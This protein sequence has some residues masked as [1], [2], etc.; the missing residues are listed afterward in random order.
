MRC[1]ELL[2]EA[3]ET[4]FF[5]QSGNRL[6][7]SFSVAVLQSQDFSS[8][9]EDTEV[10]AQI[11]A[12]DDLKGWKEADLRLHRR[13]AEHFQS[14]QLQS[15]RAVKRYFSD[16]DLESYL[17]EH[18]QRG[19][20][21][22][23]IAWGI[24]DYRPNKTSKTHAEKM[25]AKGLPE[26]EAI[27]L[28]ARMEA[29]P[30]LY[31][32][33]G[34]SPKAG[35]ID[36]EDVL[37]GS[38]VTV[39]DQMMSENIENSLFL[40]AR[41]FPAGHFHFIELAGPPLGAGMGLEAV[42]FLR[43]CGMEL[44]PEG[45]RE[46]AHMFGWLW[47]WIDEWQ[48][49]RK[50]AHLCN[51][52]GEEFLWHTASFSVANPDETRQALLARQDIQHDDQEDEFIWVKETGRG[53][54]MMGGPVTMGRI[55]FVGDELVVTVNSARRFAA[56]RRWL[57]EL[58]GVAFKSV[59]TQR[60]DEAEKDRP[61]DERIAKPEPVEITPE[62]AAS[63]QERMNK[64]YMGWIDEPLPV[65]G[66]KTPR[67]ACQTEAG[68]QQVTMLIRTM[69]DPMGPAP[70]R[71]PREAMMREL[72]LAGESPTPPPAGQE[73]PPASIPIKSVPAKPKVAR[74]APCP[75]G[76]GRKYKKCC[77]RQS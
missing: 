52:D 67:Q 8:F 56:A 50:S 23:Y 14:E 30:T 15:S 66:G 2:A 55:E 48:A 63:I 16:D 62:I 28:R 29:C 5:L 34:H 17:E 45:L 9:P 21:P 58:P 24:L 72:G 42:E 26:V 33:A 59:R 20:L 3:C 44:T 69:P 65:L 57:E 41:A 75:C 68:R 37:L 49:T 39:H 46:D 61:M 70:I 1:H 18:K 25:L 6:C 71:A 53:A 27:L 10:E 43:R 38:R 22:A 35:T 11:P 7:P 13:F 74:N 54:K 76:S 47:R 40:P 4:E 12:P 73:I 36:L 19:A 32:V 64:H 51:T 31:R 60:W 77:G